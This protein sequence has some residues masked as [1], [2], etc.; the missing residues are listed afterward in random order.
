[1]ESETKEEVYQRE[2]KTLLG[3]SAVIN[4]SLDIEEVLNIAMKCAEEF[5]EAEASSVYELDEERGLL[6]IRLARGEKKEPIKGVTLRVG[7]G[8]AGFVVQT[9]RPM[10]VQDVQKEARFSDKFDRWTGFKTRALISVPLILRGKTIGVLQV[11]NKKSDKPFTEIDLELLTAMARQVAVAIENAKLY[12]RLEEKFRYTT[13]ELKI[14]QERL[15]R[16]GRVAAMGNLVQGVAHEIRNPVMTIGGFAK[17]I[18]KSV[19]N[20]PTLQKYIDIIIEESA[21]LEDLVTK[22]REFLNVQTL[23]LKW[24]SMLPVIGE[25]I[26][27]FDD[28]AERQHVSILLDLPEDL[29]PIMMDRSQMVTALS[30][31]FENALESMPQGG[32]LS[33]KLRKDPDSLFISVSDTG[34]G[35][36]D[37]EMDAL[38]DPFVTSKSQ[39]AGL[40]LTMVHQIVKN[41]HGEIDIR[42]EL[43]KGTEVMIHLPLRVNTL[44]QEPL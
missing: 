5:M 34:C 32:V 30:N 36:G 21:R 19:G 14:T 11:I 16:T 35:I 12:S 43:Q 33:L 27:S 28:L 23:D 40:G 7:E 41:H 20:N 42:S 44:K 8:I 3:F 22:V 18:K 1:M 38:Y 37:D 9:G 39:G 15:I 6:F 13:Q 29:P 25:V 31:I 17:R 10:V 26:Q 2:L 24:D 4:S